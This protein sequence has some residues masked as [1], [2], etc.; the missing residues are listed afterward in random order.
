MADPERI[1]HIDK[2]IK[3]LLLLLRV[4]GSGGVAD[5]V[6]IGYVT[7][8]KRRV[9]QGQHIRSNRCAAEVGNGQ[10]RIAVHQSPGA[11]LLLLGIVCITLGS[12]FIK[13]TCSICIEHIQIVELAGLKCRHTIYR[14]STY[15][16]WIFNYA[17]DSG[18]LPLSGSKCRAA[19]VGATSAIIFF[20]GAKS[21][22]YSCQDQD[23]F[24][25][26]FCL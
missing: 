10:L 14:L 8:L 4:S 17:R 6:V 20:T 24:F 5:I 11:I 1:R 18:D 21:K 9:I 3:Q 16:A 13:R 15:R 25:H 12:A 23:C 19:I 2:Y 26:E 22:G 7:N